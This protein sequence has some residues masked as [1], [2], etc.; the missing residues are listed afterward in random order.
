MRLDERLLSVASGIAADGG[1]LVARRLRESIL[2]LGAFEAGEVVAVLPGGPRRWSLAFDPLPLVGDDLLDFVSGSRAPLRIDDLPE[3]ERFPQTHARLLER[4]LRSLLAVPLWASPEPGVLVVARSFGW[5]LV[6]LSMH[7]A[8]P[9]AGIAAADDAAGVPG[10]RSGR[11]PPTWPCRWRSSRCSRRR[12]PGSRSRRRGP[13]WRPTGSA[14]TSTASTPNWRICARRRRPAGPRRSAGARLLWRPTR[15]RPGCA[16]SWHGA[17]PH[18]PVPR[19]PLVATAD[20]APR[21]SRAV[22]APGTRG[23]ASAPR[24][25]EKCG[26]RWR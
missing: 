16:R 14:A 2:E 20:G 26:V 15:S 5:G 22:D 1:E 24:P 8:W 6:G 23:V 12:R 13:G 17:P 9:L 18:L 4:G 21:R 11:M 7:Y 10:P 3:A 19:A 25:Q